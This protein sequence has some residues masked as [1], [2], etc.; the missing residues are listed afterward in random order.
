MAWR[1]TFDG[2]LVPHESLPDELSEVDGS[3]GILVE[4][5]SIRN[6]R[7][8]VAT[9]WDAHCVQD[10]QGRWVNVR[11]D[12]ESVFE[13]DRSRPVYGGEEPVGGGPPGVFLSDARPWWGTI[14]VPDGT[15]GSLGF[16][17]WK[18]L[19]VWIARAAPVLEKVLPNLP[20]GPLLWHATFAG[21]V[22]EF[23]GDPDSAGLAEAK[24]D[25]QVN[26]DATRRIVSLVT[27]HRFEAAVFNV[28]NVAE[29][30]FVERA[31]EG[32]A[33][34]AQHALASDELDS[35]TNAIVPNTAARET[36]IFRVRQFRDYV[37]ASLPRSPLLID[38]A[39]VA[40]LRPG[41]GWRVRNREDGSDIRGK[42][43]CTAFLNDVVRLVEDELCDELHQ[44]D[45][46][47]TIEF[48]LKNHESAAAERDWWNRTASAVLALRDDSEATR[49]AMANHEFQ[50]NG[51]FQASRLVI[52]FA[53]CECPISGGRK[54][55]RLDFARLMAKVGFIQHVGGWSDAM[56]WDVMEPRVK[57]AALGDIFVNPDFI[58]NVMTPYGRAGSDMRVEEAVKNYGQNL[59]GREFE[60]DAKGN[61]D[62]SFLEA[63]N[64]EFG[65]SFYET[66]QFIDFVEELGL[67]KKEAVF[68]LPRSKLLD[69][70]FDDAA[71]A[72]QA[73]SSLID[74]FTLKSRSPWR[75]IPDGYEDRDI[76]PWRFRRRL[77]TLRKPL[78]QIDDAADPLIIVA[79]GLVREAFGYMLG[80]LLSRRLSGAPVDAAHAFV[81]RNPSQQARQRI[82]Q[83]SGRV[84]ARA[85]LAV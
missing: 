33:R 18:M 45:R 49:V 21:V 61:L 69:A 31:V 51:A 54:P 7:H 32:F 81:G 83:G 26:V 44:Y 58:D 60:P 22:N 23:D 30:A 27:G 77:T 38:T 34:L 24:A 20:A 4:Q 55:G 11:K 70:K 14:E 2:H 40:S 3:L 42:D 19:M 6:L 62:E 78:V 29:R 64:E 50:L 66:R 10:V 37:R 65:A 41:I 46:V 16:Q 28:E 52:E 36:H 59:R 68:V 67:L 53:L 79:P 25:I 80:K 15:A 39:D 71:L 1:R 85:R 47:A 74:A 73:V 12:G 63:W 48:A 76:H 8:E 5:N 75:A 82:Q 43:A 13:E 35:I 84:L 72:P 17:R 9:G 56:A 57:I